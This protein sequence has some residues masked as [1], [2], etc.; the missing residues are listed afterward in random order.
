MDGCGVWCGCCR[1]TGVGGRGRPGPRRTRCHQDGRACPGGSPPGSC[2]C[3]RWVADAPVAADRQ[4]QS[5][6]QPRPGPPGQCQP[7]VAV[8]EPARAE[9][10]PAATPGCSTTRSSPRWSSTQN[11]DF[12]SVGEHIAATGMIKSAA[13]AAS[14][15]VTQ[16]SRRDLSP[17]FDGIIEG[18]GLA[19]GRP[20]AAPRREMFAHPRKQIGA[21]MRRRE[22]RE[23]VHLKARHPRRKM[24]ET[25][26]GTHWP[27][28]I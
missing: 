7:R 16:A 11:R 24:T 9:T 6:G 5:G 22:T 21:P 28:S 18:T 10:G 12:I 13:G 2:W 23:H 26:P 17:W 3:V 20:A 14:Y 19:K 1:R 8:P 15:L 25:A 27:I 4:P